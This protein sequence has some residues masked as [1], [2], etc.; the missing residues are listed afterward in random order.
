MTN[1][2]APGA[3]GRAIDDIFAERRRQIEKEGWSWAHDDEHADFEL[4]KA[5]GCYALGITEV[6][7]QRIWPWS[8][9]WWKPGERRRML[10]KAGALI[11]AAIERLDRLAASKRRP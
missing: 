6:D 11:V 7:G 2:R 10:V 9:V 5:A 1:D 4:E 8:M 3:M